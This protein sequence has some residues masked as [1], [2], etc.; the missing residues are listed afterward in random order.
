[1]PLPQRE[2]PNPPPA[3]TQLV[4]RRPIPWFS[5]A[6][7]G[8]S[9][10]RSLATNFAGSEPWVLYGPA[11]QAGEWWRLIAYAV[12]HAG[13]LHLVLN[14][15]VVY[16]LGFGLERLLGTWRFAV[17]SLV[18]CLGSAAFALWFNFD[19]QTVG[20]SGMI[21]SWAGAMLPIANRATRQSLIIWL[22]QIAVISFLPFVSWSGHLGGL[23]FGLACGLAL[24]AGPRAFPYLAP[25]LVFVS[26]V[27]AVAAGHP[28]R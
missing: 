9:A 18:G 22:V 21:I 14:M 2:F 13:A 28:M 12:E 3:P 17:I 16:T 4:R 7:I 1:M 6:V 27:A 24:R 23:V 8:V 5:G 20:A 19:R 10:I 11:V 25:I 15:S 26:A